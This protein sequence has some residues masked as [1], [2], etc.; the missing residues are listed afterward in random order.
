MYNFNN[1]KNKRVVGTIGLILAGA[2][3]L[4]TI[5]AGLFVS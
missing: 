5:L 4:T 2:L 1:P 3:L